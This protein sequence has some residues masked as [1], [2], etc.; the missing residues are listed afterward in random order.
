MADRKNILTL[1]TS[2]AHRSVDDNNFLIVKDNPIAK[3]GVFE[4]LGSE[5][6]E[7]LEPNKIFNVY[8]PF[9]EL[10]KAKDLFA[11]KPIVLTHNWVDMVNNPAI[12]GS[13]TG[14]VRA[15]E[16]YLI[17]DITIYNNEACKAIENKEACE[18]S[19]G[20]MADYIK[21][22]GE[23]NGTPY[24]YKQVN[25]KFNHLALVEEGRSGK[26]LKVLDALP[27]MTDEEVE[28]ESEPID[29][30]AD[31]VEVVYGVAMK[32]DTDFIGGSEEKKEKI[33]IF[34][35]EA[36]ANMN[37]QKLEKAKLSK[38][39]LDAL[40]R[41]IDEAELDLLNDEEEQE[42]VTID[43][44]LASIEAEP[45]SE[46]NAEIVEEVA[47]SDVEFFDSLEE[48]MGA[49]TDEEFEE[50]EVIDECQAEDEE[51]ED[52]EEE[53]ALTDPLQTTDAKALFKRI[54]DVAVAKAVKRIE[55]SR[56]AYDAVRG[57]TGEFDY[58]GKTS[59]QIYAIGYEAI[60]GKKIATKDAR[61]RFEGY[62]DA[63]TITAKRTA[64]AVMQQNEDLR[65]KFS[66]FNF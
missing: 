37:K 31:I 18:L 19:P 32:P 46:D 28:E 13:I 1:D 39:T 57:Y 15:E 4:Y 11:G 23:Y 62:I 47:D 6:G 29:S 44:D 45:I 24:Q 17:A 52:E 65:K 64:D 48:A 2:K 55:D 21:E 59:E 66:H 34:I 7:E 22:E 30:I 49:T 51:V 43:T 56:K 20:Y 61:A 14:E 54:Q 26:D 36:L 63:R 27:K 35:E 5:I 33:S 40:K 10:E 3:S 41:V 53:T 9:E 50:E 12:C 16:P 58:S 38:S 42:E 8:R 25:I 60:S